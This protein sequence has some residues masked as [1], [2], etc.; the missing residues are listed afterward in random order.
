[1]EIQFNLKP[2]YINRDFQKK[3][4]NFA[5]DD[6]EIAILNAPTGA[7]KTYGFK[8]MVSEG[9]ILILLPNNLLSEEV[10][11]TFKEDED[12]G[13]LNSNSIYNTIN[14]YKNRGYTEFTKDDA[15]KNIITDKKIIISNPEIFY[16][17][18]LNNYK[19][20]KNSDS[21]TDFI[22]NGLRIIIVDEV[23][24]YTRDQINILL[25][26]L[27][28][29]NKNLKIMFSSATIPTDLKNLIRDL[30]GKCNVE[31]INAE[32]SYEYNG[33][34]ILLQGP[35]SILI[36]DS[37]D[38]VNFIENNIDLL[39][40]GYWFIIADTIRNID[41][42]FNVLKSFINKNEIAR[43]DAFH[44]P[45]YKTY[46]NIFKH[47]ARIVI[48]SNIIE[49]GI[50]PPKEF[51]NFIIEPG[52]DEKN[53]IQRFGRI[54]RNINNTSNL[55]II[56]KSDIGSKDDLARIDNFEDFINN[57]ISKKL[58]EKEIIFNSGYIGVYA[59]LIADKFSFN[60]NE[61]IKENFLKEEQGTPFSKSFNNTIRTLKILKK[62]EDH[63]MFNKIRKDIPD[64]KNI[65]NWWSKYYE[66]IFKFIPSADKG[67][68]IDITYNEQFSYDEIWI[69]KNRNIISEKNGYYTV[70]GYNESPNYHFNVL[71]SGIPVD[72][73]E[74]EYE[75]VS[76]YNARK[77]ILE[78]M[79]LNFNIDC[80]GE[81]RKLMEGMKDIVK[82]TADYG[83]LHLKV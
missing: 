44:D 53:F 69:H 56:F 42:I 76:P 46:T 15:I 45:E 19:N 62:I 58:P 83:R 17:I 68:G 61:T 41:S 75:K 29:L 16:Y 24:I 18:I 9:F 50:N 55:I 47:G 36:P 20:S 80:E 4:E 48:G 63:S 64:L 60:L 37:H 23:H 13:I 25:A 30:F 26:V 12:V 74:M 57:F 59:A 22:I 31:I 10:Y 43:V 66:T 79:N 40:S 34:N 67:V 70:V 54:G 38:I 82:A 72:D 65:K 8:K 7:G 51:N 35:V 11:Q 21:I 28:L 71:V 52:L 73:R 32:R 3:M 39:K 81:S 1:M 2:T 27:K 78:N 49:Q 6:K 14:N 77:L 5:K 33:N